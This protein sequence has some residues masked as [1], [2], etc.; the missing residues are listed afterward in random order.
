MAKKMIWF[1]PKQSQLLK[2]WLDLSGVEN[3]LVI[4][5]DA[6]H[7]GVMFDTDEVRNKV[8]IFLKKHLN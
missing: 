4:V 1:D 8:M 7:F 3:E 5:K 6:P 2:A